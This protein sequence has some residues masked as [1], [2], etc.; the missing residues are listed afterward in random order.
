MIRGMIS[1]RKFIFKL[2]GNALTALVGLIT[3]IVFLAFIRLVRPIDLDM[4][5]DLAG[6]ALFLISALFFLWILIESSRG[7]DKARAA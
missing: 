1:I 7:Y 6:L 5:R 4:H 3:T 2:N